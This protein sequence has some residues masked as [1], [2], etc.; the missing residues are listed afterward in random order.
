MIFAP[1]TLDKVLDGSKTETR[2]LVRRDKAPCEVGRVYSIQPGRGKKA[3]GQFYVKG[4][5]KERL[6]E[7]TEDGARREGFPD[8]EAFL[9]EFARLNRGQLA[10]PEVW[11]ITFARFPFDANEV[12]QAAFPIQEL[13]MKWAAGESTMQMRAEF[14]KAMSAMLAGW[15]TDVGGKNFVEVRMGHPSIGDFTLTMQRTMPDA[16][17]PVQVLDGLKGRFKEFDPA[18]VRLCADNLE[19]PPDEEIIL[20]RANFLRRLATALEE[21][22]A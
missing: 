15:F 16:K 21:V 8:R 7:I 13:V 19:Y 4:V 6:N 10:N 3:V 11:V 12:R 22:R 18:T 14:V 17:T 1:S 20:A 5:H 2:R 9:R